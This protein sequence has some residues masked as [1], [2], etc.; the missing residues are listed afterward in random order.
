METKQFIKE[1]LKEFDEEFECCVTPRKNTEHFH[2]TCPFVEK[3][4]ERVFKQTRKDF[5]KEIVDKFSCYIYGDDYASGYNQA[6]DDIRE[7]LKQEIKS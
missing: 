7:F 6:L 4:L 2:R 1:I 3:A 5:A